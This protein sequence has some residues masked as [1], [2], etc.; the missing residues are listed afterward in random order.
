[1]IKLDEEA[2]LKKVDEI[3]AEKADAKDLLALIGGDELEKIFEKYSIEAI[4]DT[5]IQ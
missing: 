2:I 5:L 1:M 4:I 3:R